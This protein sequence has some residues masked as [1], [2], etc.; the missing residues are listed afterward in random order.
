MNVRTITLTGMMTAMIAV[1]APVS[2]PLPLV[3]ITLQTLIIPLV[4]SLTNFRVGWWSTVLYLLL[5]AIGLPVFSNWHGGL[6]ILFGPT[7]GYLFGMLLF[8]LIIGGGLKIKR[9]WSM[10]LLSNVVAAIGQLLFGTF[11]LI[12]TTGITINNGLMNGMVIFIVPTL[13]KVGIVVTLTVMVTRTITVPIG[14]GR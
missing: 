9:Q 14:D 11:W 4:V 12:A 5:G 7:G 10:L 13:V 3:P 1:L 6:S 8:P 2:I